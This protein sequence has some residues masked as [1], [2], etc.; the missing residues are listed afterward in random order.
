A[1]LRGAGPVFAAAGDVPNLSIGDGLTRFTEALTQPPVW[2]QANLATRGLTMK[3]SV[4]RFHAQLGTTRTWGYGG[5]QYGG[6]TIQAVSGTPVSYTARN[7]L[8]AH[9]LGVDKALGGA[10]MPGMD[11]QT[12]PRTSLHLHGGYTE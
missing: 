7:A 8:G 5:E 2:N 1:G 6:P 4:H 11:D 3:E 9:L 12:H 10:N